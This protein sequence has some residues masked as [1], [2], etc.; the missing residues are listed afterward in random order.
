MQASLSIGDLARATGAKVET[1][2]YY[3]R[4]GVLPA[5]GRTA[6]NYRAYT[7]EHLARLSF[8]RRGRELGF[9]LG[10]IE[11]L[12]KLSDQTSA[13]CAEVHEIASAHLEEI[14]RK[15]ADLQA[16]RRELKDVV[17]KCRTGA[18]ISECRLIDALAPHG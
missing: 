5:P 9:H 3:E 1:I 11:A 2:R 16:L 12:L 8:I 18:A 4:I 6:G 13:P 15:I 7:Q 17:G 14:D 10:Q